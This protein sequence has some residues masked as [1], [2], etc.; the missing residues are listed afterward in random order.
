MLLAVT[1]CGTA[2][3]TAEAEVSAAATKALRSGGATKSVDTG[4]V[5]LSMLGFIAIMRR[6]Y[7]E[8]ACQKGN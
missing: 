1:V 2:E 3:D 5:E 6:E 4:P 7:L 8:P